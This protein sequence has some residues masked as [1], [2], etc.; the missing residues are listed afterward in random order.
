MR[1]VAVDKLAQH[2]RIIR[3]FFKLCEHH[4]TI[5]QHLHARKL[6]HITIVAHHGLERIP[7]FDIADQMLMYRTL[8]VQ[9]RRTLYNPCGIKGAGRLVLRIIVDKP[10]RRSLKLFTERTLEKIDHA[11][12]IRIKDFIRIEI[13]VPFPGNILQRCVA[14][15]RIVTAPLK[16]AHFVRVLRRDFKR[17]VGRAGVR[18]NQFAWQS[19]TQGAQR[20]QAAGQ[21]LFFIFDNHSDRQQNS[22]LF[23]LHRLSLF[24]TR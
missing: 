6:A 19:L 5:T 16:M 18:N 12:D 13:H 17:P 22:C 24:P 2:A 14:C 3:I 9:A 10:Q 15:R 20:L 8:K 21:V 23:G 4:G 7:V 11:G 1:I